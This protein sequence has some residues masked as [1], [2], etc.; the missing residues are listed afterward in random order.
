ML[1]ARSLHSAAASGDVRLHAAAERGAGK[2]NRDAQYS[3]AHYR[4]N[5]ALQGRQIWYSASWAL[6]SETKAEVAKACAAKAPAATIASKKYLV[7]RAVCR[8]APSPPGGRSW[9]QNGPKLPG[10]TVCQ[11]GAA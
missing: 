1:R 5:G 9:H 2:A 3:A 10:Y 6:L 4:T 8:A 7:E 11:L